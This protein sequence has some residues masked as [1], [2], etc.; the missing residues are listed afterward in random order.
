[1]Q[2]L[3]CLHAYLC[4]VRISFTEDGSGDP[5][6]SVEE[7]D[8]RWRPRL[9]QTEVVGGTA[10]GPGAQSLAAPLC[11]AGGAEGPPPSD[12]LPT[13]HTSPQR[14]CAGTAEVHPRACPDPAC[15][16]INTRLCSIHTV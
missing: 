16:P 2:C 8:S 10:V 14:T 15:Q 4:V 3:G 9:G 1:M 6:L 5:G 7:V 11:S 13:P 12:T